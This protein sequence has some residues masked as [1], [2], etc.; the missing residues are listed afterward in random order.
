MQARPNQL[1]N[2]R[3]GPVIQ[4]WF[5]VASPWT[6]LGSARFIELARASDA[7]VEVL[8]MELGDVFAATGGR[9]FADRPTARKTYRQLELARWSKHLDIPLTLEPRFYPVDRLPASC[10]V[11]AASNEAGCEVSDAANDTLP[12]THAIL[13]A[14]WAEDRNI[15]DWSTLAA[16][17]ND[18]GLDGNAL[19]EIAQQPATAEQYRRITERAIAAQVFGAPTYVIEGERFW[20]QDRLDFLAE[21]I[22]L[23]D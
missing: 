21:R 20:G 22:G 4:Y 13:R 5:S 6:W 16:I 19:V 3:K 14:I 10:L 11:I 9:P 2:A 23:A 1:T 18:V 15:A 7:R 17:A 12:L 8:P